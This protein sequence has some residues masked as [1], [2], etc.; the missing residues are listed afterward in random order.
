MGK[1]FNLE[2]FS[3]KGKKAIVTGGTRGLCRQI[4]QAYH[5]L[6]AEV[7]IWGRSEDQGISAARSMAGERNDVHFIRCDL[8]DGKQIAPAVD[9]SLEIF[10]GRVDILVNGAGV[11]HRSPA[12]SFEETWWRMILEVNLT[13]MF[14]VSQK[15]G[16]V[17]CAQRRGRIINIAS[18]CSFFGSINILAYAASKG[19]V[20]QLTKALSNEWAGMGVNVNAIAP[21]YMETEI[22]RDLKEKNPA[23]YAGITARIPKGRWGS[24]EDMKG[25]AVFLAS[26]ASEY[27]TGAVIPL[28]GGY[29]GK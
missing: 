22:T 3:L 2:S 23:Q 27:M 28:D 10:Q 15:V 7:V 6:G 1:A 13:S 5:D 26:D 8:S 16:K 24:P 21:G 29:L 11:Q 19:G 17:M 25:L 14:L 18:M 4:A 12:L 20:A 9:K